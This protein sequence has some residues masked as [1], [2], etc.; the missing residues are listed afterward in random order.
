[1]KTVKL[2]LKNNNG[3]SSKRRK[4]KRDRRTQK[5]DV[6]NKLRKNR[7]PKKFKKYI[8]ITLGVILLA[9][10]SWGGFWV[11]KTYS[12]LQRSGVN[13]N[14]TATIVNTITKKEPEL[15]KDENNLTSA[16]AVGIDTRDSNPGLKNTDSIIIMTLNHETDE[17][18]MLSL[19]RDL[20]VENPGSPGHYTKINAV[21]NLCES[22]EEG[23]GMGCLV[24]TA[25]T[26]TGL[27]I[28]YYGMIDIAGF[29]E[30]IDTI[31]GI[32]VDVDNAFT[33]YMF[34]TP[35]NT[36][37][38]ISFEAGPQH[39]DGETAMKFARSRHAQSVEGSDFARAR[40]QQKVIIA[41]KQKLLSTETL[42]D[43]SKILQLM[44]DLSDSIKVSDIGTEDIR[45]GLK[46]LEK[47]DKGSIYSMV[48]DPMAGNWTLIHEDPSSAYILVPKA[49][50]N[51]WT[52]IHEFVSSYVE[53]PA[54]YSEQASIYVYNGGLGYGA[55]NQ[56]VIELKE[57]YPFLNITFGGNIVPQTYEGVNILSF[58]QEK[59]FATL[60]SLEDFFD[61]KWTD[62]P[63]EGARN[64][65][66]EDITIILGIEVIEETQSTEDTTEE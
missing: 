12:A 29:V 54:L 7:K 21:Y 4:L 50:V 65:Y 16:L 48:L 23:S 10:L 18:T 33:D 35:Q 40:R 9:G 25:E 17:V 30:V 13:P 8:L 60:N 49:G 2:D 11:Y 5:K 37:E 53:S 57:K 22:Y 55:A 58:S 46:Q 32:E 1:M 3:K 59:K 41:A 20:W 51:N 24:E 26:I 14:P 52:Q 27:N 34:P 63:P 64:P 61:Q 47:I 28:Q 66:G 39:M 45:A 15:I 43:P 56:K 62:E 36:Y 44:E 6:L 42:L 38:T 19:P 31:G